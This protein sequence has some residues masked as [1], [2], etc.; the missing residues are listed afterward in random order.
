LFVILLFTGGYATFIHGQWSVETFISSY[1]NIPI[2]LGLYFGYKCWKKSSI[3]PLQEIP[4]RAFI[5]IYQDN[6]D[7]EPKPKRGL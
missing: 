1:I 4:I 7:P 6:P 5:T 2:I 3:I